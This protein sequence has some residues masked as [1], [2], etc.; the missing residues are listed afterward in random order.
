MRRELGGVDDDTGA[1]LVRRGD[2][3]RQRHQLPRH[4]ARPRDGDEIDV[5]TR[6]RRPHHGDELLACRRHGDLDRTVPAPWQEVGVVLGV[7]REHGRSCRQG[8]GEEVERIRRVPRQHDGVV[9]TGPDVTADEIPAR[10]EQL[11]AHDGREPGAAVHAARPRQQV[12][13]R[14]G[15]RDEGGRAGRQVEVDGA[16]AASVDERDH[17]LGADDGEQRCGGRAR[18]DG[19]SG[20]Q[21]GRGVRHQELSGRGPRHIA[22]TLI[23]T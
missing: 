6:Q 13:H 2:D 14:C 3:R 11:G 22:I 4:V 15:D 12:V 1:V 18:S 21:H 5:G 20:G 17:Q 9:G 10:G 16:H 7:E 23:P 8:G 19:G